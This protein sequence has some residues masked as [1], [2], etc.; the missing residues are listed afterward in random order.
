VISESGS[1]P[2]A[3]V[4][5]DD[6][7]TGYFYAM[8]LRRE[9]QIVDAVH[10]YNV[11]SMVDRQRVSAGVG[12]GNRVVRRWPEIDPPNQSIPS[13]GLRLLGEA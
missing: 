5:E 11:A 2:F 3:T 4:F 12:S 1:E 8:D 9:E 7:E 10:I 13:C 6:G